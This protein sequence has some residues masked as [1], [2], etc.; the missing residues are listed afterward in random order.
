MPEGPSIVILRE[1]AAEF[2]GRKV[3]RVTGNSTQDI[4]RLRN[5]TLVA[6][7]S[8]GKHLLLQF[9][10][11]SVRIHFLLFGSYRIDDTKDA[12]VRL[13]LGFSKGR[14]L[15]FY[16]CSV[17]FIEGDLD[18]VYDWRTDVMSDIWDP[19]AARRKLRA[20]PQALA[21][22]VL[23]DQDVFAG[24]GNIIKNEVLHRIRVHPESRIGAL[25]PRKLA[26]LVTQART[27]SFDFYRW[28]LAFELR[29]HY[30]V[31][32]KRTCPR[33]GT[34]LHY[35]KRLGAAQRRAFWCDT[36]QRLYGD[37]P[38]TPDD[39]PEPPRRRTR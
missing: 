31:H 8:W 15:N 32:T 7:R 36:C 25:P 21:A 12:P 4:Q 28:K 17:R 16:A 24:V 3:L 29:K 1:A 5:R 9:A 13:G 14:C 19:A 30:Q 33:D 6:V 22:D 38:D 23:L 10:G 26:E 20:R 18:A 34:P 39:P 11:F 2:A 35:R 37:P 27:Y